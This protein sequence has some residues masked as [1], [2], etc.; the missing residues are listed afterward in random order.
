MRNPYIH[1]NHRPKSHPRATIEESTKAQQEISK[2][3]SLDVE[4]GQAGANLPKLSSF[5]FSPQQPCE[6]PLVKARQ[7][8]A[9]AP[10]VVFSRQI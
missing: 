5:P 9:R 4:A 8:V 1:D 2:S 6:S 7:L 3:H 10:P